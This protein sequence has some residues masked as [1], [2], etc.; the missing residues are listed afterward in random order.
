MMN[1]LR[2]T[3]TI[4]RFLYIPFVSTFLIGINL[5]VL[6]ENKKYQELP[7]LIFMPVLYTGYKIGEIGYNAEKKAED[8]F[9]KMEE[10]TKEMEEYLKNKNSKYSW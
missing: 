6:I 1:T 7:I 5:P 4:S 2:T 8:Y 3:V 9:K 10:N